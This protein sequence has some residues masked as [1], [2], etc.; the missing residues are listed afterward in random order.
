M[1]ILTPVAELPPRVQGNPYPPERLDRRTAY[2]AAKR[3][4]GQWL[5]VECADNRQALQL[6]NG[7]RSHSTWR[8]EAEQRGTVVY[9]RYIGR[10][11]FEPIRP[12]SADLQAR[13]T[14]ERIEA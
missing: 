13:R 7:A 9:L 12:S 6:A 4:V 10:V 11:G 8:L 2:L 3:A 1:K 5:P 14:L